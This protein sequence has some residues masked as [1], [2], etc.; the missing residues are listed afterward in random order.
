MSYNVDSQETK[1]YCHE[2]FDTTS[3]HIEEFHDS[4]TKVEEFKKTLLSLY[5]LPSIRYINSDKSNGC[6]KEMFKK[7]ID[8]D[9]L[10]STLLS[11]KETSDLDLDIQNFDNQCFAVK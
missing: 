3:E 7:E 1:D 8:N 9:G 5:L 2:D 10:C 6:D 11:I 4:Q